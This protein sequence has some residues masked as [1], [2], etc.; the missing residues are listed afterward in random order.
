MIIKTCK[1]LFYSLALLFLFIKERVKKFKILKFIEL[2]FSRFGAPSP[3]IEGIILLKKKKKIKDFENYLFFSSFKTSNKQLKLMSLRILNVSKFNWFFIYLKKASNFWK[4]EEETFQKPNWRLYQIF[5]TETEIEY[6]SSNYRFTESEIVKGKKLLQK[7]GL[8]KNDKW[9]CVHNRDSKYLS[10]EFNRQDFTYHNHRDFKIENLAGAAEIFTKNGF[11]V[12]RMGKIQS[13]KLNYSNFNKKVIDYAFSNKRSDFLD[14]YLLGNCEFFLGGDSGTRDVVLSFL[15]PCY[16]VNMSPMD[17]YDEPSFF[18]KPKSKYHPWLF[19]FKRIKCLKS[20]KKLS[21]QEFLKIKILKSHSLSNYHLIKKNNLVYEENSKKDIDNLAK[22]II[23]E[24]N[25]KSIMSQDDI[26]LQNEFW[27]I[28]F[29][30]SGEKQLN[31]RLPK[32]SPAFLRNNT[33]LLN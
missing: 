25:G 24:R 12:F 22:E 19:M 5:K 27:K 33:D 11:F 32:L 9:V 1:I 23:L 14:M 28:Y 26:K 17:I 10:S 20:G 4:K 3:F 15:K 29:K 21:L 30:I 18:M 2:D 31:D 8:S 13:E 16:A 6:S 7:F